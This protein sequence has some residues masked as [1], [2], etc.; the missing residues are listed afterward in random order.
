MR[1]LLLGCTGF[2]G[3]ELVPQLL[4]AQHQL[5][6]VSRR[7]P[8]GYDS[9]RADGR[10]TWLQ[11]DP[12]QP[13]SWKDS[14]MV[15]ALTAADGVVNLAG[16]PI[17]EKRWS[18]PLPTVDSLVLDCPVWLRNRPAAG[19]ALRDLLRT[20]IEN[21]GRTVLVQSE[22]D[23]SIDLLLAEMPAGS[24]VVLGLRFPKG[25]RG[26]LRFARRVCDQLQLPRLAARGTDQLEPWNYERVILY[27]VSWRPE[28]EGDR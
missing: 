18:G 10:I 16:E 17:A 12:A 11:L 4:Q 19:A 27:L 20:R 1:L 25:K 28:S 23:D 7:L 2:V 6:V 13:A 24:M 5:T 14:A 9:E 22:D 26:K 3:R 21:G 15:E 8:R